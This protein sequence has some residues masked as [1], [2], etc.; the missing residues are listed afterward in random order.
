MI[1]L[2][3]QIQTHKLVLLEQNNSFNKQSRTS[4]ISSQGVILTAWEMV[5][6][7]GP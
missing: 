6:D 2:D 7:V 4:E 5:P 3:L 1:T